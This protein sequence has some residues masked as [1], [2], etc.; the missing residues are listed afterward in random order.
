MSFFELFPR[1]MRKVRV[2]YRDRFEQLL[3]GDLKRFFQTAIMSE[4]KI[5]L[6]LGR[7]FH[8][9]SRKRQAGDPPF[10]PAIFPREEI[11]FWSGGGSSRFRHPRYPHASPLVKGRAGHSIA[12]RCR[13]RPLPSSGYSGSACPRRG[14]VL[15]PGR[16]PGRQ[17]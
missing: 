13:L 8:G 6:D 2:V 17:F 5:P 3:V 15:R 14:G 11:T 10:P 9:S 1:E 12:L 4:K 7:A 16:R